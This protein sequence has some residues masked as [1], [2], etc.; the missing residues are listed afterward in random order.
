MGLLWL[1]H[2]FVS[3]E[4]VLVKVLRRNQTGLDLDFIC[5]KRKL[6]FIKTCKCNNSLPHDLS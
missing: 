4:L 5:V 1:L 6:I 3:S 2:T